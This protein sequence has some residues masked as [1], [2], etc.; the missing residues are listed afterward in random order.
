MRASGKLAVVQSVVSRASNLADKSSLPLDVISCENI[1]DTDLFE[2]ESEFKMLEV[3]NSLEPLANS[4]SNDKYKKLANGLVS[5][6]SALSAFF[7]GDKSVMVMVEDEMIRKNRLNLL[8]LLR[9]Q[10][11]VIADFKFIN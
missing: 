4:N 9:N 2:K 5:G 10:A 7:D 1:I 11:R 6:A 3:I 8:A